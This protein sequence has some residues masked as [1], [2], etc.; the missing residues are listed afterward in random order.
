[1][2][3]LLAWETGREYLLLDVVR[4]RHDG[5]T[6]GDR[7]DLQGSC[8]LRGRTATVVALL[9]A[10]VLANLNAVVGIEAVPP[11]QRQCE[12]LHLLTAPRCILQAHCHCGTGAGPASRW[13]RARAGEAPRG[14]KPLRS[15]PTGREAPPLRRDWAAAG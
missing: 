5:E 6:A 14:L 2:A 1:M 4:S 7:I 12:T 15:S 13:R 10:I 3:G 9:L 8:K 11:S